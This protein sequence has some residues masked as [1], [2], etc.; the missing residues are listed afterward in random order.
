LVLCHLLKNNMKGLSFYF[1]LRS[2]L[3]KGQKIGKSKYNKDYIFIDWNKKGDLIYDSNGNKKTIPTEII[4]TAY[5][6]NTKN[7]LID[8]NWL[9]ANGNN[10]YCTPPVLK[11]LLEL[12]A[13]SLSN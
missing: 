6:V 12:Y 2:V 11:Y 8:V 13:K 1:F 9:K 7:I 5:F 4:I 10:N 3:K